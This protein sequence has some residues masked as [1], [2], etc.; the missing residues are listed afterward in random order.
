MKSNFDRVIDLL[1]HKRASQTWVV[2]AVINDDGCPTVE[3]VARIVIVR[4]V[5]GAGRLRI[6][7]TDWGVTDDGPT[8]HYGTASG[9]GYDKF[10]AALAGA[11]VGGVELGDHCDRDG[12]PLLRELCSRN[13]WRILEG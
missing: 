7:V 4:P 3:L 8:H 2:R 13:E 12:H 11:T 10:T 6:G 1:E 9:Y 5:D